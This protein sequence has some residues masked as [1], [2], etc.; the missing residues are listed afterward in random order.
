M[1][2]KVAKKTLSTLKKATQLHIH[3]ELS[4]KKIE[5]TSTT[6]FEIVINPKGEPEIYLMAYDERY[7]DFVLYKMIKTEEI[8]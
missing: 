5:P 2:E 4:V 7:K 1:L 8:E 3:N 6:F